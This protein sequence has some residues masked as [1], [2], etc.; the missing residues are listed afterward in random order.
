MRPAPTTRESGRPSGAQIIVETCFA[1]LAIGSLVVFGLREMSI[2][3]DERRRLAD[4]TDLVVCAL[5]WCKAG[6]DLYRAPSKGGWFRW[7]WTDL[8]ASI[9]DLDPLRPLRALRLV[10]MIRVIRSTTTGVHGIATYFNVDRSR[11]IVATI[12]SLIVISVLTSSFVVL[13]LESGAPDANILTAEDALTWS[14][15]TLFGADFSDHHTVTTGGMLVSLWLVI[16]SLGLIGSLAGLI[17][18]WIE[19]ESDDGVTP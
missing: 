6:W 15:A 12:F 7:G 11:A 19:R 18:A 14:V 5:F 3:D 8:A 17:S 10:M 2:L 16:L 1:V 9:P 13:G 4:L